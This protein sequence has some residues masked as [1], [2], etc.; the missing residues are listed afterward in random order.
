MKMKREKGKWE[1]VF[2]YICLYNSLINDIF[3]LGKQAIGKYCKVGYERRITFIYVYQYR[4]WE[5]G[6]YFPI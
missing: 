4:K 5:Y 6:R 3:C 1:N 2:L